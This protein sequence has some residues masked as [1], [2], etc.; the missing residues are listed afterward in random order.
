MLDGIP[1]LLQITG[2]PTADTGTATVTIE[3]SGSVRFA[4]NAINFGTGKVNTSAGN[5]QCILDSNGTNESN[6]CINFT[7]QFGNLSLENDGSTNV[8]VQLASNVDAVSFLGGSSSLAQF[9]YVVQNNETDS[10]RNGT[11][12]GG[13][14]TPTATM[15]CTMGKAG[16]TT[17]NC[18]VFPTSWMDVNTTAPGTT[19][20]QRLLYNQTD[21]SI[22][23]DINISIPFDAPAGVKTA[24]F[25][26]TATTITT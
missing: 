24:T 10:C 20:C 7:A 22:G 15:N 5:T 13:A 4:V 19:I 8:T 25:T 11:G 12:G 14:V 16:I 26:A 1:G 3:A 17:G 2:A 6:R 23:I 18:T 9:R 21:D